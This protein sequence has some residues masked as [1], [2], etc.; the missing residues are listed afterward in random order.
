[1]T[2]NQSWNAASDSLP[3]TRNPGILALHPQPVTIN[4]DLGED[5]IAQTRKKKERGQ[6]VKPSI[7]EFN[8][9]RLL[10]DDMLASG[11]AIYKEG[12][13]SKVKDYTYTELIKD[14]RMKQKDGGNGEDTNPDGSKEPK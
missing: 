4:P 9:Y 11:N 8:K 7:S 1:M 2:I 13:K 6:L 14:M 10:I 5:S 12:D 3:K